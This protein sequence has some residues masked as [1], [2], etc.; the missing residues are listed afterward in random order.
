MLLLNLKSFLT[1]LFI[2]S[3]SVLFPTKQIYAQSLQEQ[4]DQ[5]I[6]E[7]LKQNNVPALAIATFRNGKLLFKKGYGFADLGNKIPVDANSG[8][9]IGSISKMF[10]AWGVMKLV[11]SGK[12]D[13]DTP[14]ENYISRWSI[15]QSEFNKKKVTVRA[16]LGH[17]A[18]LSV[19]GYP[20]FPPELTLPTLEESLDGVNG[21]IRADEPVKLI[22]EPNTKFKY[23]GGGYT[24]LQLMIE[25]VTEMA[26][27]EYMKETIFDPLG[28]ENTSFT[29][30]EDILKNSA[31]PYDEDGKE[32]YLERFTAQAAAGLHTTLNDFIIFAEENLKSATILDSE[33][34]DLMTSGTAVSKNRYGLGYMKYNLGQTSLTGHAGSN[35]GWESAFF[36]H[37]PSNS[38]IVMLTN[39]SSGKNVLMQTV[40]VWSMWMAKNQLEIK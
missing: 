39:G 21:P 18:G 5:S 20:G 9:N 37:L 17:T 36:L 12:I 30:S 29:I 10:T 38:A 28:M 19:H 26:F 27:S 31:T 16:L 4:L 8:F 3:I 32:I 23:S 2:I 1:S 35:D 33:Y 40:R 24:I 7:Q 11:E 15:P 13:L 6:P 34:F 25:E 14:V 22:H